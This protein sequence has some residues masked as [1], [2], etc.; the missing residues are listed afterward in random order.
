[1]NPVYLY[2][3]ED[4]REA[5]RL[6]EKV[7]APEFISKYLKEYINSDTNEILDIGCGPAEIDSCLGLQY[8]AIQITGIDISTERI[9]QATHNICLLYTSPSPRDGLLSRM[10]SS[11]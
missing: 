11:A 7:D 1:M 9:K 4:P 10:P 2:L 3:M 5:S 8:P 6:T